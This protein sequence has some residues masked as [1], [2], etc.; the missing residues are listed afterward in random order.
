[1]SN[2]RHIII[3][4]PQGSG[5]SLRAHELARAGGQT[6]AGIRSISVRQVLDLYGIERAMQDEPA[7]LIIEEVAPGASRVW[8]FLS[9][10]AGQPTWSLQRKGEWPRRVAAPTMIVTAQ[11][12]PA[13]WSAPDHI[14]RVIE[15]IP[16]AA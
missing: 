12:L 11:E 6:H 14:W 15:L 10:L 2:R 13:G 4:G 8:E 9:R 16:A 1:V 3:V 5:K 7:V